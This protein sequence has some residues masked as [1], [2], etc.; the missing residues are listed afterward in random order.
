MSRKQVPLG[1]N[2]LNCHRCLPQKVPMSEVCHTCGLWAQVSWID[3][4]TKAPMSEWQCMDTSVFSGQIEIAKGMHQTAASIRSVAA[5]IESLRNETISIGTNLVRTA[6]VTRP[7]AIV[8][9]V[10]S[11]AP[12]KLINHSPQE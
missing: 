9:T 1:P 4:A 2:D 3:G 5:A 10:N 11:E 12:S 7:V 8:H 6:Q